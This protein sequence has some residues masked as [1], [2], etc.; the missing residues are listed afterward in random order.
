MPECGE[1]SR[2]TVVD[3]IWHSDSGVGT[4]ANVSG[5][6]NFESAVVSVE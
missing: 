5:Y 2:V 1:G 6:V 3:G 4:V